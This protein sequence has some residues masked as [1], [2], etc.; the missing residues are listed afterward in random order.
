M[1]FN[2]FSIFCFIIFLTLTSCTDEFVSEE[3]QGSNDVMNYDKIKVLNDRLYFPN[4]ST[5]QNYYSDLRQKDETE[6][7]EILHKKF[8]SKDFY[9]LKPIVNKKTEQVEINRHIARIVNNT[10]GLQYSGKSNDEDF[11]E[12][13]DDLE[14]IF[15]E[16]L[17]TS[18]LNQDAEIQVANQI[19]KYT[20]TGLFITEVN[21][22]NDLNT[23]LDSKQISKNL[24][25]PTPNIIRTSYIDE[26]S[27]FGG[28]N[29]LEEGFQHFRSVEEMYE[30]PNGGGG[31]GGGNSGSGSNGTPNAQLAV[32]ANSLDQCS[33]SQPWFGNLFGTTKVCKDKYESDRR[34]KVKFYD[35]DLFL[36]YAIGIKTKHQYKGWTG[37]WR[38]QDADEVAL[39]VNSLTWKFTHTTPPA[40]LLNYQPARYYLYNG[41]MYETLDTYYNAV[42]QGDIPVPNLPFAN[43]TDIIVEI[44]IGTPL[45][46]LNDEE[47]VREFVYSQLY[48]TAKDILEN[49]SNRDLKKMGV[50]VTTPTQTWVQFYDFSDSCT[51]CSKRE[52]VIDF[53][54]VT[55]QITYTFGA[56]NGGNISVSNFSFDF[57]NPDLIGMS[58]FGMAKKKWSMA[59]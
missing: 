29:Y 52:N 31:T 7:A 4:K 46:P 10:K 37:I 35:I 45:S 59:W 6:V 41:K 51:N 21:N 56:G 23:Y 49:F 11:L 55:P 34:V 22:I 36:V 42:Y 5:F 19:Y 12:D 9:S 24:L 33:G 30:I 1:K 27:P 32:I 20:D 28:L 16:D 58:A 3:L 54:I 25:V 15:G 18:F 40:A 2:F 8:Y 57:D 47:D 38:K 39:G 26:Y 17:F 43:L 14:D 53:G 44:A 13:F 50:V 48:D